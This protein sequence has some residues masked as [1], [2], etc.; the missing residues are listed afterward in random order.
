[1]HNSVQEPFTLQKLQRFLFTKVLNPMHSVSYA[2]QSFPK[3]MAK[4][5]LTSVMKSIKTSEEI[6]AVSS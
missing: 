4:T 2:P 6:V 3:R 1:M 5:E